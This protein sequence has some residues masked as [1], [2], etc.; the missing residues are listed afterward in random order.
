[1]TRIQTTCSYLKLLHVGMISMSLMSRNPMSL[2]LAGYI[3]TDAKCAQSVFAVSKLNVFD[4]F[5]T[6]MSIWGVPHSHLETGYSEKHDHINE[7]L[8]LHLFLMQ[9]RMA[10][11]V[12]ITIVVMVA[13]IMDLTIPSCLSL[14]GVNDTNAGQKHCWKSKHR[15]SK[16]HFLPVSSFHNVC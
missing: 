4:N 9:K 16:F 15:T 13:A 7:E 3:A 5:L 8:Y 11:V 14:T 1:M 2:S 12:T 10:M 6:K